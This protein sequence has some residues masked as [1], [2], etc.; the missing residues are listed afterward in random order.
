MQE[1]KL[2][3]FDVGPVLGQGGMATVHKAIHRPSGETVALKL[4]L[5]NVEGDP[6]FME[7]FRREVKASMGLTHENICRVLAAGEGD[8][9]LFMAMEVID[10]GSVRELKQ[11]FGGRLP[12]QLAIDLVAQLLSALGAAHAQGVIHRDLKPANL[13]LTRTGI[14]KLVD[15]GI[16]KSSSDATLTATGMLVGTPAYMSPEQVRGDE[17][18]GRSDLFSTGL[19]LHDLLCGRS[20]YYSDNP[21]TSLMK[22]LQEEVPGIFDVLFG[23]DPFV[24]AFHGKLTA[25]DRDERY[26]T[27]EDALKAIRPTLA[28]IR[29]RYP[30]LVAECLRNPGGM[31]QQ[32][33]REHA[34]SEV[35]RATALI[36]RHGPIHAAALALENAVHI[37]P[38]FQAAQERLTQV[39][40]DL[41]FHTEV[42]SEPRIAEAA[43]AL[44][45]QP[46]HPGLLKRLA[47]LHRA[48]GNMRECAK[49][50]KRYLRQKE[51]SAAVQQLLALLWGPG[52]DP[53]LVTGT[54]QRL[55]TQDIVA[56]LKTGGMSAL[57][58][59]KPLKERA[60]ATMTGDQR[61]AIAEAAQRRGSD[62]GVGPGPNTRSG[63]AGGA[64]GAGGSGGSGGSADA[65]R[66]GGFHSSS[67]EARFIA[68]LGAESNTIEDLK[69]RFGALFWVGAAGAVV[70][71]FVI[72][73]AIMSKTLVS[74]AQSDM[75]KH[76]QGEIIRE[77]DFMFNM[78]KTK[79]NEAAAAMKKGNFVGCV[80]AATVALEGE[81]TAKMVL[82]AKWMQAQCSL[83]AGDVSTARDALQ[84]FKDNANIKDK[85]FE[86]A[87]TQLKAIE[88]GETP[89]GVRDL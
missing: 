46:N 51:D 54:I 29:A 13:M 85:R 59:E 79:L 33:L 7:R 45:K 35:A 4:M 74:A 89:G 73:A 72:G 18:D 88:R 60:A 52:S 47:D 21:G 86:V 80:I 41:G 81:K 8:G 58:P 24:E 78:Q 53:G 42:V 70:V 55:R 2:S 76:A 50:L 75:K 48:A 14:L 67:D 25:K 28:D 62:T 69:E 37:D 82:D 19:I 1:A 17:L 49:Y 38:S 71:V 15:F 5:A 32:L 43:D 3:D 56:G 84:D 30:R 77:E 31:K 12:M 87:K 44:K 64:G 63:G 65:P 36:Q 11:K 83:M 27:C 6:T 57:K 26:R 20:P 39:A 61:A 10:G 9:R 16:A 22:V 66:T 40:G 34:E 23:I 68:R